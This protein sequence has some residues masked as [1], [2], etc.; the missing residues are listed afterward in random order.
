MPVP[1][2]FHPF[3][4]DCLANARA[5]QPTEVEALAERIWRDAS[6]VEGKAA[7][8]NLPTLSL[9]RRRAVAAARVAFGCHAGRSAQSDAS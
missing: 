6:G 8:R 1:D 9:E 3:L 2:I 5:P 4:V 7:W